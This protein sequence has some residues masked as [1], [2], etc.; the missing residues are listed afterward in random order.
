MDWEGYIPYLSLFPHGLLERL[1]W[2]I[3]FSM[4]HIA[5]LGHPLVSEII[6]CPWCSQANTGGVFTGCRRS[7]T[8]FSILDKSACRSSKPWE[9][10]MKEM[11]PILHTVSRVSLEKRHRVLGL[12][13]SNIIGSV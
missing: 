4:L 7:E 2:T 9:D 13:P 3:L 8:H 12:E 6:L 5:I 11:T 1:P 10:M